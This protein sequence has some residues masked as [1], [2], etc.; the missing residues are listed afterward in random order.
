MRKGNARRACAVAHTVR[1]C[2]THW[3][4]VRVRWLQP[5]RT[6]TR[7]D[8]LGGKFRVVQP[9]IPTFSDG[10]SISPGYINHTEGS[11][12]AGLPV[13]RRCS[14]ADRLSLHRALSGPAPPFPVRALTL[15]SLDEGHY[16]CSPPDW[17]GGATRPGP[18]A[19]SQS[20]DTAV[21]RY[22]QL[23]PSDLVVWRQHP[24][25]WHFQLDRA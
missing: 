11:P 16:Q 12:G 7:C 24:S 21:D 4:Y 19:K 2:S 15:A 13:S 5:S 9:A 20:R 3:L 23:P 1:S 18:P 6:A 14:N 25:T 17:P 10:L 8:P 22:W